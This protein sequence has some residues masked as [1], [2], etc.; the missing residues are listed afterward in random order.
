[1][2]AE[3]INVPAENKLLYALPAGHLKENTSHKMC[4]E[5]MEMKCIFSALELL[6]ASLLARPQ[7]KMK[8][9]EGACFVLSPD[10]E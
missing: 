10:A 1:M 9:A 6:L 3:Q 2:P 7:H 4:W 8:V 5:M